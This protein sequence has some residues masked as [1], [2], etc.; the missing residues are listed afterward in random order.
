[1]VQTL[2]ESIVFFFQKIGQL[3]SLDKHEL[4]YVCN[5]V[6]L[7]QWRDKGF[8]ASDTSYPLNLSEAE[9][10]GFNRR[11][12]VGNKLSISEDGEEEGDDLQQRSLTAS[13]VASTAVPSIIQR[14]P[15]PSTGG[16]PSSPLSEFSENP[17]IRHGS[18]SS[19][20]WPSST[21]DLSQLPEEK[22][23]LQATVDTEERLVY[24]TEIPSE[25]G[26]FTQDFRCLT[27]ST[28][29]GVQGQDY[30]VCGYD[31]RYYCKPCFGNYSI[32][33][34]SRIIYNWDHNKYR[35][36]KGN[37]DFLNQ[38]LSAPNLD[39]SKLNVSLYD[40]VP[41]LAKIRDYR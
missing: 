36:S 7:N 17:I 3:R 27:C 8:T 11:Y 10:T 35:V 34:P 19:S 28:H 20:T 37:F 38:V 41:E 24:F 14:G 12:S 9:K 33:I 31:K 25:D 16:V 5:T 40:H 21:S 6:V 23:V 29:I 26:L 22:S 39:I 32:V 1:M 30:R 13:T 18:F 4:N 15:L 2:T